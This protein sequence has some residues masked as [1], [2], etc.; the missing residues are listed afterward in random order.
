[1]F[2]RWH[3]EGRLP[4]EGVQMKMPRKSTCSATHPS[5]WELGALRRGLTIP[6]EPPPLPF[7]L[8]I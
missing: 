3:Y 7:Q 5:R 2:S 8:K 6:P 4:G 1:M